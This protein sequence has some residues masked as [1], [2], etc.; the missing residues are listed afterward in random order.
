MR[1]LMAQYETSLNREEYV[2]A[3]SRSENGHSLAVEQLDQKALDVIAAIR[4]LI[5]SGYQ[6]KKYIY[7]SRE[8]VLEGP[9]NTTTALQEV[10]APII[11]FLRL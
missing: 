4:S 9:D 3:E 8:L 11:E 7:A 2:T 10:P 6:P 5:E 1:E